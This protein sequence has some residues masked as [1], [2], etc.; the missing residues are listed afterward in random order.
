MEDERHC[1]ANYQDVEEDLEAELERWEEEVQ[2]AH[3]ELFLLLMKLFFGLIEMIKQQRAIGKMRSRRIKILFVSNGAWARG[4][5]TG[6]S[7]KK[8]NKLPTI[9]PIFG[10][11][12]CFLPRLLGAAPRRAGSGRARGGRAA[13]RG[14]VGRRVELQN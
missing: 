11:I 8:A 4:A 1:K 12:E 6:I 10:K 5:V 13:R 14:G 3:L 9:W 7:K 2:Q